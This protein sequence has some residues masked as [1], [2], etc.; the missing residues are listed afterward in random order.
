M[1]YIDSNGSAEPVECD[2][3][4][5]FSFNSLVDSSPPI[6]FCFLHRFLQGACRTVIVYKHRFL[7]VFCS[8][9]KLVNTDFF[10][11]L[12]PLLAELV[13]LWIR[14]EG[15]DSRLWKQSP[16]ILHRLSRMSADVEDSFRHAFGY[17]T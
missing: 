10:I 1:N 5:I 11:F 17:P 7:L 6:L 2:N 9:R 3:L 4:Y 12:K 14:F 13:K 16:I 15:K 8:H